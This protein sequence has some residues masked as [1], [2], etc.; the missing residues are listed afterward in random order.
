MAQFGCEYRISAEDMAAATLAV[1]R[2]GPMLKTLGV[3]IVSAMILCAVGEWAIGLGALVG[4]AVVPVVTRVATV[5]RI[6]KAYQVQPAM[7]QPIKLVV[8]ETGLEFAFPGGNN[9]IS[10]RE[11]FKWDVAASQMLIYYHESVFYLVPLSALAGE[12]EAFVRARLAA[13]GLPIAGKRRAA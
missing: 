5:R 13:S 11:V 4:A 6:R 7:G 3:V 10:W 1:Y 9:S 12:A 2:R 8:N